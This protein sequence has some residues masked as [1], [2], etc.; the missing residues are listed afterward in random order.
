M[1]NSVISCWG[2]LGKIFYLF[3]SVIQI[4]VSIKANFKS[5]CNNNYN[6]CMKVF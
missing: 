3:M 2:L 1:W 5:Y 4:I 6:I